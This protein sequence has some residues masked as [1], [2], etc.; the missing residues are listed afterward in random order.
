MHTTIVVLR[1]LFTGVLSAYAFLTI[2]YLV[3]QIRFAHRTYRRRRTVPGNFGPATALPSVDVII[4]CFNEQPEVLA[5]CLRSVA[6]QDYEGLLTVYVVDDGSRNRQQLQAVYDEF[7]R[8]RRFVILPLTA[9]VGKRKAQV[10]AIRQSVGNLVVAIDSDTTIEPDVVGKLAAAMA[11]PGV[12]AAMGHMVASNSRATWLTRLVNMEYWIA[13]NQERAAQ[14]VFGAVMCCCGPCAIY[15]R[16]VLTTVLDDYETQMFRG[17]PSDFGED[18]HLT[19]L[20]LRSGL[21]TVYIPDATAAT[22]VP[23]RIRPYLRQQ[24][25]WARSTYRDTLLAIR[26]LPRLHRYLTL[27]VIGQNLASLLLLLSMI[28][29]LALVAVSAAPPPWWS[30]AAM[31]GLA[32]L[33]CIYGAWRARNLAFFGFAFHEFI[34]VGLILPLKVYALCTLS[35]TTWGSRALPAAQHTNATQHIITT[36]V[37]PAHADSRGTHEEVVP[38]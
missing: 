16:S 1:I 33:R 4:P 30:V 21:R 7:G 2:G 29:G 9:N 5:S 24:L 18:R 17:R 35:N 11:D 12:G 38:L 25:R 6:N 14:S 37:F 13:C 27:D 20:I 34:N 22:V 15:R 10:A 3:T 23:E 19:I 36:T 31:A 26:L 8:D 32:L 28:T